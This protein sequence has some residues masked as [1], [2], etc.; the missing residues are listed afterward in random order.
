MTLFTDQQRLASIGRM[1]VRR[2]T[3]TLAS[4]LL[5]LVLLATPAL[6]AEPEVHHSG[7]FWAWDAPRSFVGSE[8]ANGITITGPN[9]ATLDQ[10]FSSILCAGGA[11]WDASVTN[12][13]AAKR[14]D[15]RGRG[16]VLSNVSAIVHPTGTPAMYRRQKMSFTVTAAGVAKRGTF[17]FDYNYNTTVDTVNYC[18]GRNLGIYANSAQWTTVRPTLLAI[19]N[20]LV[21]FG[22][23]AC[24]PSP[25]TPC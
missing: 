25:S 17:T 3:L 24:T 14:R 23:G 2:I 10:G 19:N 6:A 20:S 16:F 15:L 11:N 1:T 5:A 18:Y 7:T 4:A 9:G 8:S 12:Y 21:Y 13:F 22:P